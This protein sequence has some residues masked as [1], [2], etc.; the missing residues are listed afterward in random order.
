MLRLVLGNAPTLIREKQRTPKPCIP[1][2]KRCL[3]RMNKTRWVPNVF[4]HKGERGCWCAWLMLHCHLT[5]TDVQ[6]D[7][8]QPAGQPIQLSRTAVLSIQLV[9]IQV[10]KINPWVTKGQLNVFKRSQT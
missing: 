4:L 2:Q 5:N 10:R 9:L 7:E 3:K 8:V 1:P 6:P